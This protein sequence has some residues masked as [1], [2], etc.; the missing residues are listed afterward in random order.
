MKKENIEKLIKIIKEKR[1]EIIEMSKKCYKQTMDG[2]CFQ[3]RKVGVIADIEYDIYRFDWSQG[4]T[5]NQIYEG[6]AIQVIDYRV[7]ND[8]G[9]IVYNSDDLTEE[10]Q[11]N[12]KKFLLENEYIENIEEWEEELTY[13]RLEEF[14]A[15]IVE[16]IDKETLEWNVDEY[17]REQ[18]DQQIDQ[19]LEDLNQELENIEMYD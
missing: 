15:D 9:E 6:K 10:E 14:N 1:E 4:T 7:T 12:F 18:A 3:G 17:Y 19:T 11:E 16:R 2:S 13:D 8:I 5:N